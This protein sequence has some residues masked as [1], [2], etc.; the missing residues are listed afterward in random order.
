MCKSSE[1]FCP[2]GDIVTL[3]IL[4]GKG[5]PA[6][7]SHIGYLCFALNSINFNDYTSTIFWCSSSPDKHIAETGAQ[8]TN[9]PG[10]PIVLLPCF[11]FPGRNFP[12]SN[13]IKTGTNW[14]KCSGG[15]IN[16]MLSSNPI[17][18]PGKR[19]AACRQGFRSRLINTAHG[20]NWWN[21]RAKYDWEAMH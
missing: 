17:I 2:R 11:L 10:V 4:A 3:K 18:R 19:P 6:P 13:W 8:K 1:N 21:S 9:L 16:I 5:A 15:S 14:V 20:Q 12:P 7:S